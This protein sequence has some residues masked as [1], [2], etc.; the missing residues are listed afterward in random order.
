MQETINYTSFRIYQHKKEKGVFKVDCNNTRTGYMGNWEGGGSHGTLHPVSGVLVY[1]NFSGAKPIG[2][3]KDLEHF[4]ACLQKQ[5]PS[6][7]IN[8]ETKQ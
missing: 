1:M 4:K 7:I 8:D 6:A 5:Y 2:V 3:Y